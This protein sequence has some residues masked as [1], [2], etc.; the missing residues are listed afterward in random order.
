MDSHS[1]DSSSVDGVAPFD[2]KTQHDKAQAYNE[3]LDAYFVSQGYK[4]KPASITLDMVGIDRLFTMRGVTYS[5]QYKCDFLMHK[6][7]NAFLETYMYYADRKEMGCIPKM[8]ADWLVFFDVETGNMYRW[9][10]LA[11]KEQLGE[12]VKYGWKA[13]KPVENVCHRT[14]L[15]Y[16]ADG[17]AVPVDVVEKYA[18]ICGPINIREENGKTEV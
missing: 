17:Y 16:S 12:I 11:V 10:G 18:G 13:S 5:V 15:P 9:L 7:N 1:S 8:C 4:V 3:E 14:G 6:T 2:F